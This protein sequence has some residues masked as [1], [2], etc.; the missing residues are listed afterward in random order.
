MH[1]MFISN[2][3]NRYQ[4]KEIAEMNTTI[5]GMINQGKFEE[6]K[7]ALA[8][9]K[10]VVGLPSKLS[11]EDDVK[12]KVNENIKRFQSNFIRDALND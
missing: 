5:L 1:E 6:A 8:I 2:I 7:G 9:A 4:I 11:R 12:A 3:F 10:K